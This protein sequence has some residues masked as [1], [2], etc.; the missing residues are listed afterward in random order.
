MQQQ[1][2]S[3]PGIFIF[4]AEIAILLPRTVGQNRE[5]HRMTSHSII[6]RPTR[7][8]VSE[9]RMSKRAVQANKLI[10]KRVAQYFRLAFWLIWPTVPLPRSQSRT[11]RNRSVCVAPLFVRKSV[12][13]VFSFVIQLVGH[14]SICTSLSVVC[15]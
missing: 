4:F 14:S 6:H 7:E 11:N 12:L 5:K 9:V 2:L 10:D 13:H 8:G 1:R 15:Y 3:T